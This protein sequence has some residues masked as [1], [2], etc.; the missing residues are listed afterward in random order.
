[1]K[2]RH[3][4][5]FYETH[6]ALTWVL[7]E[8]LE[9]NGHLGAPVTVLEPCSGAGAIA[10]V[11]AGSKQFQEVL[12]NDLDP[13]QASDTHWDATLKSSWEDQ[14]PGWVITNPP[15]NQAPK[16]LPLAHNA[17]TQGVAMLLR[18]SYLEPCSDLKR[19]GSYRGPWLQENPPDQV[20]IVWPR[21][22][23]RADTKGNDSVTVGWFIWSHLEAEK[24]YPP[25]VFCNDWQEQGQR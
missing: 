2:T 11:L 7:L 5:D 3:K 25:L 6:A 22:K 17:S 23:F 20:I 16:I 9:L 13:A 8:N 14:R 24:P 10:R 19:M 21:P 18:L 4:L 12:T 15:F 1:M